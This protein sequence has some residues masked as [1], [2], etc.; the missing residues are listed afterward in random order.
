M[1]PRNRRYSA[2]VPK[3]CEREKNREEDLCAPESIQVKFPSV[4]QRRGL[5]ARQAT[6]ACQAYQSRYAQL[7]F[8]I[9]SRSLSVYVSGLC[10]I[11]R[12]VASFCTISMSKYPVV[13]SFIICLKTPGF[14][15]AS[16][17]IISVGTCSVHLILVVIRSSLRAIIVNRRSVS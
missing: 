12:A 9:L 7:N 3:E 14:V 6:T 10:T 11:R 1:M 15:I 17:T 2:P 13:S 5:M 8:T 4:G 16:A